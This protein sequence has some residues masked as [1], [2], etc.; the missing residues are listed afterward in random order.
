MS[1]KCWNAEK[2]DVPPHTS[3]LISRPPFSPLDALRE[4]VLKFRN[5]KFYKARKVIVV[6]L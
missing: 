6:R 3:R 4:N 1:E 5:K 2:L